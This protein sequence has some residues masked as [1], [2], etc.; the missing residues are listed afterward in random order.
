MRK[1]RETQI[2]KQNKGKT[3]EHK[4]IIVSH[5]INN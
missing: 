5:F 1:G 2:C 3:R 4:F